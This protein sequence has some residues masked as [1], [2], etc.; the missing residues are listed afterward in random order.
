MQLPQACHACRQANSKMSPSFTTPCRTPPHDARH[1][2]RCPIHRA[3]L[4]AAQLCMGVHTARSNPQCMPH[5]AIISRRA[6]PP[7]PIVPHAATA[8][9]A[10][11]LWRALMRMMISSGSPVS[12]THSSHTNSAEQHSHIGLSST[13]CMLS[14]HATGCARRHVH[15]RLLPNGTAQPP[16]PS[17]THTHNFHS[18]DLIHTLYCL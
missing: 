11:R 12:A 3:P 8:M 15:P 14:M 13:D 10:S 18:L 6:S 2:P 7:V 1:A 16:P 17:F 4:L 5:P 9:P